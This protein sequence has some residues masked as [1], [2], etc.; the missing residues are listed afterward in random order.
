MR[1]LAILAIGLMFVN[2]S[3]ESPADLCAPGEL[4]TC[5][6]IGG[7]Q[8]VQACAEDRQGWA[9]C[10]CA[11]DEAESENM[12]APSMAGGAFASDET[13]TPDDAPGSGG[14]V[15]PGNAP[16]SGGTTSSGGTTG[17]GDIAVSGGTPAS[18]S[19]AQMAMA[20]PRVH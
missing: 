5:P 12:G 6:C 13:S 1:T 8:G 16:V 18:W 10:Q 4:Q 15:A 19:S 3:G 17:F 11:P 9:E 14:T 7:E 20:C 2:C